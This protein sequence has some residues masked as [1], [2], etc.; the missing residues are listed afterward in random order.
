V[1]SSGPSRAWYA[2]AVGVFLLS[3][4]PAFLLGRAVVDALDVDVEP[5]PAGSVEVGSEQL[6][7]YTDQSDLVGRTSCSLEAVG[8]A[9]VQLEAPAASFS[10]GRDGR[11]W[12]RIAVTP[13]DLPPGAYALRCGG[14]DVT[15]GAGELGIGPNPRLLRVAALVVLAFAIPVVVALC[16]AVIAIVT[17]VRR[18]RA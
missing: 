3:L 6:A 1:S 14:S 7:V 16:G 15:L 13:S 11:S 2:V 9:R 4:V 17:A 10:I 5:V 12:H 8:G 18:R